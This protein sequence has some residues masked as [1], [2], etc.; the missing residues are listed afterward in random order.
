MGCV[1]LGL[2]SL[3]GCRG[4]GHSNLGL[5]LVSLGFRDLGV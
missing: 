4:L 5:G 1:F 2:M 3:R